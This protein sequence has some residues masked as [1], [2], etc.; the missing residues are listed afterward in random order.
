VGIHA[1]TCVKS[2]THVILSLPWEKIVFLKITS[3][4]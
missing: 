1:C 2:G 4:L 3:L